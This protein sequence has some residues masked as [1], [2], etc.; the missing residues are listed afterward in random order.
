M[1]IPVK[2]L[3]E[4][5][6]TESTCG[7]ACWSAK[8][9]ICRCSCGGRNHGCLRC[10][11]GEPP[12]R[13]RR[14]KDHIYQLFAVPG[15]RDHEAMITFIKEIED[16]EDAINNKAIEL[17]IITK[18][19]MYAW[20]WG[21]RTDKPCFSATASKSEIERWPELSAWRGVDTLYRPLILWVRADLI[22]KLTN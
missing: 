2:S 6:L 17:G 19:D 10:E 20:E 16:Q 21:R 7:E 9:D 12:A 5:I 1:P 22:A 8:E 4:I 3:A 13:T 18:A 11:S 14:V 15:Y